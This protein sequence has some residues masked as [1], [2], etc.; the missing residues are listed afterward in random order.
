MNLY[1]IKNNTKMNNIHFVCKDIKLEGSQADMWTC[2]S[3]VTSYDFIYMK[4]KFT[5]NIY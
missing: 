4:L 2:R 1:G 3:T 5:K